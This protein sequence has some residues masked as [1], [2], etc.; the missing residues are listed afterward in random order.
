MAEIRKFFIKVLYDVEVRSSTLSFIFSAVNNCLVF[1]VERRYLSTLITLLLSVI[2]SV[3]SHNW[4]QRWISAQA[5]L[6]GGI[7]TNA[8][9]IV[10]T[11]ENLQI[12]LLSMYIAA[13]SFFHYG[14]F[15]VTAIANRHDLNSSSYLLDHSK[16]YWFAQGAS[17]IEYGIECYLIPMIKLNLISYIGLILVIIGDTVR[18]LAMLHAQ[19]GFTHL[20]AIERRPNHELVTNGI[21]SFMRHPGYLGWLIWCIGT[22]IV[23]C[24]PLCLIAFSFIGWKFFDERIYWEERFL[25]KFFGEQYIEYQKKV[26]V[27]IPLIKGYITD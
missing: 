15:L 27:G 10:I 1:I 24:N 26:P 17:C 21:Y 3:C 20:I 4:Q 2:L 12:A 14:E 25:I 7:F 16:A 23:V 8:F 5:A 18:K 6:L 13:V 19:G 11:T 22:Q 9:M